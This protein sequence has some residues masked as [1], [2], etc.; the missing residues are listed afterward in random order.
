MMR[1]CNYLKPAR[2]HTTALSSTRVINSCMFLSRR[3]K[4]LLFRSFEINQEIRTTIVAKH[5]LSV[6]SRSFLA[7]VHHSTKQ[8]VRSVGAAESHPRRCKTANQ[9]ILEVMQ[10]TSKW[11]IVSDDW[12]HAAQMSTSCKLRHLRRSAVQQRSWSTNQIKKLHFCGG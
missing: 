8:I 12:S 2:N 4:V 11:E 6:R 3:S 7:L 5:F 10:P 1:P 9:I